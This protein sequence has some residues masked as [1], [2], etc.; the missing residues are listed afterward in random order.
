MVKQK[1]TIT[2]SVRIKSLKKIEDWCILTFEKNWLISN[3]LN[4]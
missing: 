1:K 2:G 3:E 4:L